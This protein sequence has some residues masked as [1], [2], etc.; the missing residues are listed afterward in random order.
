MNKLYTLRPGDTLGAIARLAKIALSDIL[1]LNP[2]I[3]N[4]NLVRAG[5]TIVLPVAADRSEMLPAVAEENFPGTDPLWLKIA[6]GEENDGVA[7]FTPGSNPR[8]V[9]YLATCD[10]LT[11][12]QRGSDDTAW[13]SAFANWCMVTAKRKGTNSAWALDWADWG[14]RDTAPGRGA[15]VVW[16]RVVGGDTF[17]HVGFFLSDQGNRIEVIG[18]N[19]SNRVC[20]RVFPKDGMVGGARYRLVDFRKP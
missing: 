17:G 5:Q 11:P 16:K 9:E 4:P 12:A 1:A 10:G 3:V 18:G 19:Q 14:K 8:I 20:R 2:Q 15:V 6:F 13:C 7:E